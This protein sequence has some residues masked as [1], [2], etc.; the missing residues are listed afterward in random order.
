MLSII[1]V[2][3]DAIKAIQSTQFE[4]STDFDDLDQ[5]PDYIPNSWLDD[6]GIRHAVIFEPGLPEYMRLEKVNGRWELLN[7]RPF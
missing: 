5:S 3:E 7:D 4:H 6:G 1:K 2:A